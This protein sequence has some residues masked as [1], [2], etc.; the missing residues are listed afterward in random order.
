MVKISKKVSTPKKRPTRESNSVEANRQYIIDI[1]RYQMWRNEQYKISDWTADLSD[2]G[3]RGRAVA[4]KM[5]EEGLITIVVDTEETNRVRTTMN[6][7]RSQVT[8]LKTKIRMYARPGPN[9]DKVGVW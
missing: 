1:M 6:F 9:W 4:R 7:G 3:T 5:A 2:I 8:K